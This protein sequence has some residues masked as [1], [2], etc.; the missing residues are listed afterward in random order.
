[1]RRRTLEEICEFFEMYGAADKSG[2]VFIYS[3]KPY[4]VNKRWLNISAMCL[5]VWDLTKI[6][7]CDWQDSLYIPAALRTGYEPYTEPELEWIGKPIKFKGR[8]NIFE[9]ASICRPMGQ[10]LLEISDNRNYSLKDCLKK[11]E[12]YD[13]A[14]RKLTPFG[15]E[16]AR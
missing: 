12:W 16:V 6:L 15:K 7:S 8:E 9:I 11:I 5:N 13:P 2:Y 10:W 14:T 1:M 3:E 4:I